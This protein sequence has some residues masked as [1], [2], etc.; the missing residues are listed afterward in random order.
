ME[1]LSV[2]LVT[3]DDHL[4]DSVLEILSKNYNQLLVV[5]SC[6]DALQYLLDKKFDLVIFDLNVKELDSLDTIEIIKSFRPKTPIISIS[7]E[8]SY[9]IG[10]KIAKVGVYYRIGKPIDAQVTKELAQ[11]VENKLKE[12]KNNYE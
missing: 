5:N 9:E 4:E 6:K 7:D 11:I 12:K 8:A 1:K 10:Q 3:E 2:L